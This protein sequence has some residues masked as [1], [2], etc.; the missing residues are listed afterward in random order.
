LCKLINPG[1]SIIS[2]QAKCG[3]Q[4]YNIIEKTYMNNYWRHHTMVA[5]KQII[6]FDMAAARQI[7]GFVSRKRRRDMLHC[8]KNKQDKNL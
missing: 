5:F 8:S 3:T 4:G 6:I 2:E 7:I 1:I